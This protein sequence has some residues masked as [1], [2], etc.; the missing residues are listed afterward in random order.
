MAVVV[1]VV[2]LSSCLSLSLKLKTSKSEQFC[3][4][5][6]ICEVD[7]IENETILRDF[8]NF[9]RWQHQKWNNSARLPSKMESWVQSWRPRT[10][11]FCD[12]STPSGNQRPDLLTGLICLMTTSLYVSCTAPATRNAS[13]QI[14]FKCPTPAM[15]ILQNRFLTFGKVRNPLRLPCKR[16]LNVQKC[17]EPLSFL[18]F[19][20]TFDFEMCFAPQRRALFRHLNF[21]KWSEPGVLCT[22][23]LRNA[24]RA[25][26]ACPFST[27]QLLKVLRNWGALCLFHLEMCFA[28]QRRALFR[29]R[30]V[31]KCSEPV[32]F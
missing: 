11:A 7:N 16:H 24:L 19:W 15:E 4:T 1:V 17:S 30:K 21:Q 3:Q 8:L 6:S 29:H 32:T 2:Y 28:P 26:T 5:S 23:W 22:F 10:N 14:L 9:W 13:F 12:S 27:S 18:H 31:Q 20:H 25:T